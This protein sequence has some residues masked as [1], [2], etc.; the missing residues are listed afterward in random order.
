MRYAVENIR[1][2]HNQATKITAKD[3]QLYTEKLAVSIID[4][5]LDQAYDETKN[6]ILRKIQ[7]SDIPLTGWPKAPALPDLSKFQLPKF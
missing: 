1:N 4:Q 3:L 2:L 5:L 7:P 6:W